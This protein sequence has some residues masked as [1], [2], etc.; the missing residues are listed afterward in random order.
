MFARNS[1][2]QYQGLSL[3]QHLRRHWASLSKRPEAGILSL[4]PPQRVGQLE[5]RGTADAV[6]R[7]LTT[8][9]SLDPAYALI[10]AADHAYHMDYR[11][12]LQCHRD[13][14]ADVTVGTFPAPRHQAP[15]FGIMT[16][17]PGGVVTSFVEKP[18]PGRELPAGAASALASMGIYLFNFEVLRE[19]LLEDACRSSTH[20]FGRDILPGMLG[21]YRMVAF[22]FVEG[23]DQTPA[24]SVS[25][26][27]RANASRPPPGAFRPCKP[28][29]APSGGPPAAL[30]A[31]SPPPQGLAPPGSHQR[32]AGVYGLPVLEGSLCGRTWAG[33]GAGDHALGREALFGGSSGALGVMLSEPL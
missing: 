25:R 9:E 24:Y 31:A 12:L 18:P 15:Q 1:G 7:H 19:I 29:G 17:D 20:D 4:S 5:Y 13:H 23:I 2:L 16:V 6:Y 3:E 14:R 22:P 8:L 11:Q 27:T 28:C 32:R 30:C 10:L 21:R 33:G 26:H